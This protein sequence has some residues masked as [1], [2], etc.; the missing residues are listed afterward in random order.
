[1]ITQGINTYGIQKIEIRSKSGSTEKVIYNNNAITNV[2]TSFIFKSTGDAYYGSGTVN[3]KVYVDD[4]PNRKHSDARGSK[5]DIGFDNSHIEVIYDPDNKERISVLV[6]GWILYTDSAVIHGVGIRTVYGVIAYS[7]IDPISIDKDKY[8][9]IGYKIVFD[10]TKKPAYS[11]DIYKMRAEAIILQMF[12]GKGLRESLLPPREGRLNPNKY[13][14]WTRV[15]TGLTHLQMFGKAKNYS[16]DYNYSAPSIASELPEPGDLDGHDVHPYANRY[17]TSNH[18]S[19]RGVGYMFSALGLTD[20]YVEDRYSSSW[21][22]VRIYRGAPVTN[23]SKVYNGKYNQDTIPHDKKSYNVNPYWDPVNT[24]IGTGMIKITCNKPEKNYPVEYI[25]KI[26]KSG[27]RGVAR[28]K[29]MSRPILPLNLNRYNDPVQVDLCHLS[30]NFIEPDIPPTR[31]AIDLPKYKIDKDK[32]WSQITNSGHII[33]I[34]YDEGIMI[35]SMGDYKVVSIENN[36]NGMPLISLITYFTYSEGSD[37]LYFMDYFSGLFKITNITDIYENRAQP[38]VIKFNIPGAEFKSGNIIQDHIDANEICVATNEGIFLS[39]DR[40]SVFAKILSEE[41]LKTN[42][43]AHPNHSNEVKDAK[44]LDSLVDVHFVRDKESGEYMVSVSLLLE[45]KVKHYYDEEYETRYMPITALLSQDKSV[46]SKNSSIATNEF[47]NNKFNVSI[48]EDGSKSVS[49]GYN[50]NPNHGIYYIPGV[51]IMTHTSSHDLKSNTSLLQSGYNW[52]LYKQVGEK[53]FILKHESLLEEHTYVFD[54]KLGNFVE[55]KDIN[56]A[57]R[58]SRFSGSLSS[59]SISDNLMHFSINNIREHSSNDEE[60]MPTGQVISL[61]SAAMV[62]GDKPLPGI[63]DTVYRFNASNMRWIKEVNSGEEDALISI[64]DHHADDIHIT[65]P[66]PEDGK[67]A[68]Y[69]EGEWYSVVQF[70]GIILDGGT[71]YDIVTDSVAVDPSEE[72]IQNGIVEKRE[73]LIKEMNVYG[74]I[75]GWMTTFYTDPSDKSKGRDCIG[76]GIAQ[77]SGPNLSSG[78]AL[79]FHPQHDLGRAWSID[80][81]EIWCGT[82]TPTGAKEYNQWL[83]SDM[84]KFREEDCIELPYSKTNPM[85]MASLKKGSVTIYEKSVISPINKTEMNIGPYVMGYIPR[86]PKIDTNAKYKL[87]WIYDLG[88]VPTIYLGNKDV[89][90]GIYD[91]DFMGIYR[92]YSDQLEVVIDGKH[93]NIIK[94]RRAPNTSYNKKVI[95]INRIDFYFVES[96]L[97]DD[98]VAIDEVNG[99]VFCPESALGKPYTIKYK[100]IQDKYYGFNGEL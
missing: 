52:S 13:S 30:T 2:L 66:D 93:M 73:G 69:R 38:N 35:A 3:T 20:M 96:S 14:E 45:Y 87:P 81:Q 50:S 68:E 1:M 42:I 100:Y 21:D 70:E 59:A 91:P 31:I 74:M 79:Y 62:K 24:P 67:T 55:S 60:F 17:I 46:R 58:L 94:G 72:V 40:G 65:F 85:I 80:R 34:N 76:N 16:T 33:L 84:S 49:R 25:A 56:V 88:M 78:L 97:L 29:L 57:S 12:R 4:H 83:N 90:S 26:T 95:G 18:E 28:Y 37:T 15:R 41:D 75:S 47:I 43:G 51:K 89:N 82:A 53:T 63:L 99:V 27:P 5:E 64:H 98:Q 92:P 71:V 44:R 7:K 61:A 10:T 39:S 8:L 54:D 22:A 19:S 48:N 77:C 11:P 6:S 36:I 23:W 9:M 86:T 32:T